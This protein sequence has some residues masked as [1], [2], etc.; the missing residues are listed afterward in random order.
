MRRASCW[1][2]SPWCSA[3][4][5][6]AWLIKK[7]V[8]AVG[9][10]P[11]DRVLGAVFGLVRGAVLL[12]ALAVVINMSPLK[13]RSVVDGIEG[14]RCC[15]GGA[16]GNETGIARAFRAVP[17]GLGQALE[18]ITCVESSALSATPQSTS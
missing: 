14:R 15:D 5:L 9:L 3:A 1:C 10:R 18:R 2:S 17:S 4:A 11:I 12:L 8:E 13:R 6:L 16:Q 7:L